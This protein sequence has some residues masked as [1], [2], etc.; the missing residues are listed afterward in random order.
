MRYL[1]IVVLLFTVIIS[2]SQDRALDS[3][4]RELQKDLSPESEIDILNRI[5]QNYTKISLP[6]AEQFANE[7]L[8]KAIAINYQ[9]GIAYSYN[10]LG[11]CNSIK[12][13]Y[14]KGLD[15]FLKAL[16]IRES[17]KDYPGTAKTL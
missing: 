9:S 5:S 8:T 4:Q 11:I 17:L 16:R 2:Y 10:C 15:N 3:L 14:A 1:S 7:A 12:G 13:E 6:R